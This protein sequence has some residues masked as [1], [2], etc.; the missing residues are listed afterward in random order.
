MLCVGLSGCCMLYRKWASIFKLICLSVSVFVVTS[1]CLC[2]G[3]SVCFNLFEST[4][5]LEKELLFISLLV[6]N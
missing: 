6:L 5:L 2:V 4:L 1:A 3:L